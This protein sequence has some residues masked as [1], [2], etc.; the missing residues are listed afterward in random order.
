MPATRVIPCL[1]LSGGGLVKT[2]RFRDPVYVG[3]PINAVKIFNDKEVHELAILDIEASRRGR[4]P[5]FALLSRIGREA[6]MPMSYG[7]GL[8]ALE[9][10]RRVLELGF[11]KVVINTAA[12]EDASFL[13]RA[14][15]LCGSQ[16][17][18][19]A[20]DVKKGFFGRRRVYGHARGRSLKGSPAAYAAAAEKAGA[21][22]IL[23]T[24][25]DRDGTRAGYDLDL[26]REVAGAVGV[27]VIAC[28]G[29]GRVEDFA[30]AAEAGAAAAAAGSLFVFHGPHRAVLITYPSQAELK[31]VFTRPAGKS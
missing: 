6:F 10:V 26:I 16:S 17:V 8:R 14:A 13:S 9:D 19:A 3:D 21:G 24:S 28:G 7:G 25:V 11:E 31:Q 15:E 12:L 2:E 23:L 5:D 27:P 22:E 4:G 18:V 30:L 29:A 20:V 1:L